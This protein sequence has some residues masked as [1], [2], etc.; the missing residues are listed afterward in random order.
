MTAHTADDDIAFYAAALGLTRALSL[1]P[2]AAQ[3][4]DADGAL[5]AGRYMLHLGD[6]SDDS[7]VVWVR[8]VKWNKDVDYAVPTAPP[9]FPMRPSRIMAIE[10]NVREG[11]NDQVAAIVTAGTATLYVT[12]LSFDA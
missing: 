8:T 6:V 9:A 12:K 10:F 3:I 11:V 4:A 5:P 2:V 1:T 7:A